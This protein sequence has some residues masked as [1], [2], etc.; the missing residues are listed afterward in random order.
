MENKGTGITD[1]D[2]VLD[3]FSAWWLEYQTGASEEKDIVL[4]A[5]IL[6][7]LYH[8]MG[9]VLLNMYSIDNIILRERILDFCNGTAT[10]LSALNNEIVNL[11][12]TIVNLEGAMVSDIKEKHQVESKED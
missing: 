3:E 9:R 5:K 6:M 8:D 10:T 4:P 1:I 7:N 2:N 11:R 12:E